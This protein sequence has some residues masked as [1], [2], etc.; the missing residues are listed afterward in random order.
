[1]QELRFARVNAPLCE[2]YV[3]KTIMAAMG[4]LMKILFSNK[5]TMNVL[6]NSVSGLTISFFKVYLL[7]SFV[8]A[9]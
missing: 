1:M 9:V 8:E 5:E 6:I 2:D 3:T 4:V 7:K